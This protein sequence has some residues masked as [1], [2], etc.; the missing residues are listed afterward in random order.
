M[1]AATAHNNLD[2]YSEPITA[3]RIVRFASIYLVTGVANDIV[4]SL[5]PGGV[6]SSYPSTTNEYLYFIQRLTKGKWRLHNNPNE[7]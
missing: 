3:L 1:S 4:R 2:I 6:F 7:A 5:E